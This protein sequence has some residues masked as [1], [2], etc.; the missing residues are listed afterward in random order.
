MNAYQKYRRQT[1]VPPP[2][3]IDAL[4]ALFDKALER[5]DKA[6]T[7]LGGGDPATAVAQMT[8]AQL[9]VLALASG[10][11]VEI[12]P[13]VNTCIL[14]LYEFTLQHL[15]HASAEGI[16]SARE[17]LRTLRSGFEKIRAEANEL[18]RSG[19][20]P[21][22]DRLQMVLATACVI[23]SRNEVPVFLVVRASG[24]HKRC[25][26]AARTTRKTGNLFP[27]GD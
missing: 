24:L 25:R 6:E 17:A 2:T 20:S 12:N 15:R 26:P 8:R 13:E 4:L 11:R 19:Q 23:A 3:R 18:E 9:I 14:K 22:L 21:P 10:V 1:E 7:A 16:A 27:E 5:L